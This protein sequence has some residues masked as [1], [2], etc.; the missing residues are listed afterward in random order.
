MSTVASNRFKKELWN[1]TINGSSDTFK[2]ILMQSGFIYSQVTM[3]TYGDVSASELP[4][5][6]GYT[7]GGNTLAGVAITQDD[8]LNLGKI[9]WNNTSW[10]ATGGNLVASGA[11]IYDDTHANDVVVCYIDF[12]GDVTTLNG[13]TFTLANIYLRAKNPA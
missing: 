6:L 10:V 4:T 3:G 11:I 9:A 8:T 12:G 5:A 2:C 1:S 7:I 13:G